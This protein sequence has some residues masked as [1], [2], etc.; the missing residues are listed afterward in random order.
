[1][2]KNWALGILL[3]AFCSLSFNAQVGIGHA[4]PQTTL[5]V[6]G[7][8]D[9]PSTGIPNVTQTRNDVVVTKTGQLG[10]GSITPEVKMHVVA[11]AS[12]A[13]RFSLID[14]PAGTNQHVALALRNTSPLATG[15]YSLLGFTNS[16]ATSGGANW[17]IG[18]IR[19]GSVATNGTEEELFIG[20]S[21]GSGYNERMR[22]NTQGNVGINTSSPN[23]SALL[24][25]SSTTKGFLPTRMTTAQRDAITPKPEG[26]MIYNLDIH[27]MQ[28]WNATKWVGDCDGGGS[29]GGNTITNC[30]T[31]AL[32]GN[33]TEGTVMTSGNTIVLAVNV[34]QLGAW[35]ASSNTANGVTF[36]GAGNFTV[37][38]NQNITLTANGTPSGSGYF[39]Y[40]FSLGSSTCTR[41]IAFG[42]VG[43]DPCNVTLNNWLGQSNFPDTYSI[44][45]Q[46]VAVN[47]SSTGGTGAG[48]AF[49]QCGGT[50]NTDSW[51]MGIS[52]AS[53]TTFTFSKPV[54]DI[55]FNITLAGGPGETITVSAKNGATTVS[56]SLSSGQACFQQPTITGNNVTASGTFKVGATVT[57]VTISHNGGATGAY[58]HVS[59]CPSAQ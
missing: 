48:Q 12:A 47:V 26:L 30:T 42:S 49:Q 37:L 38:G 53:T 20:N 27:C 35:S 29:S 31:T 33:Y 10:V 25:L 21:L 52:G 14:V 39:N 59:F 2:K 32:N 4:N 41:S 9:N 7:G 15:N 23:S 36:S 40:T 19:T 44:N 57:S 45:G 28:Y 1:M 56:P 8:K 11:T 13:N 6:D 3:V 18:T 5:H 17:G 16:G 34:T 24:E 51:G 58:L 46:S 50:S 54:S 55:K 22:I 43:K